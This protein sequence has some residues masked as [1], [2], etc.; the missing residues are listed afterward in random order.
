MRSI[1]FISYCKRFKSIQP[2]IGSF[3]DI[4]FFVEQ[5]I[6]EVI[7]CAAVSAIGVNI[8]H[9]LMLMTQSAKVICIKSGIGIQEQAVCGQSALF[10]RKKHIGKVAGYL[11]SIMVVACNRS[12]ASQW[13]SVGIC[14]E[15]HIGGFMLLTSLISNRPPRFAIVCEPSN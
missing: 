6:K 9:H 8:I 10:E 2:S 14:K 15:K 5:L 7:A 13:Y 4:P 11:E 1:C 3:D 12:A